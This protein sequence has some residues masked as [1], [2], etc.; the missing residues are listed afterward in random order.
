MSIVQEEAMPFLAGNRTAK[1]TAEI[2]QSR[3]SIY[4]AENA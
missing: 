4:V 1:E 2:I 3:A